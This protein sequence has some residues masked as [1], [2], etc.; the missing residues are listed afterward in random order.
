VKNLSGFT[1]IRVRGIFQTGFYAYQQ[2]RGQ[3]DAWTGALQVGVDFANHIGLQLE[4]D[5]WIGWQ[6]QDKPWEIS[7][8]CSLQVDES[9]TFYLCVSQGLTHETTGNTFN[10]SHGIRF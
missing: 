5:G 9:N 10:I 6:K 1:P 3:N 8:Q 7:A 4:T 2:D